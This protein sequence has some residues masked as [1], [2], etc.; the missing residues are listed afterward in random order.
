MKKV[1]KIFLLV[2]IFLLT[3]LFSF[4]CGEEGIKSIS[5]SLSNYQIVAGY[6][7]VKMTNNNINIDVKI[8]PNTIS[9]SDL[10][11][12]SSATDVVTVYNSTFKTRGTGTATITASYKNND[13]SV[14]K[15]YLRIK[16]VPASE[17]MSFSEDRYETNYTGQSL[18]S[19]YKVIQDNGTTQ[20]YT[21]SY[22]NADTRT[23]VDDI[24]DVGTYQITCTKTEGSNVQSCSTIL[25]V[26]KAV[27]NIVCNSYQIT[28]GDDFPT[29]LYSTSNI[30]EGILSND[31]IGS[32]LYGLG[33]DSSEKIGEYIQVTT[34]TKGANAKSYEINAYFEISD[35][36]QSNYEVSVANITK[37]S[38]TISPKD[39]V[40]SINNQ[41]ITY[42]SD[43]IGNNFSLYSYKEYTEAGNDISNL[44]PLDDT[45]TNYSTNIYLGSA[46]F[47]LDGVQATLN[48]VNCLNVLIN[49]EDNSYKS[50][51]LCYNSATTTSS[52]LYI[53]V[54][55]NG[56]LTVTPREVTVLPAEGQTKIFGDADP[57]SLAYT[58]VSG[59]FINRD[60]IPNFLQVNYKNEEVNLGEG[61]FLAGVNKY[62]YKV[63]NDINKN[64]KISL[65][66]LA[67]ED[68]SSPDANENKIRFEVIKSTIVIKL[69]NE[70]GN[71]STPTGIDA[72][73]E[74]IHSL[75]Y[76]NYLQDGTVPNY[77]AKPESIIINGEE[78]LNNERGDI[79]KN[80]LSESFEENG[81]ILLK[82]G[83]QLKFAIGLTQKAIPADGYFMSYEIKG[84]DEEGN[85]KYSLYFDGSANPDNFEVSIVSSTLNLR[86]LN[87]TII[88]N[89]TTS[90]VSKEYDAREGESSL[91]TGF[92]ADYRVT[93]DLD[94]KE[95][96]QILVNY[97]EVLSLLNENSQYTR[98]DEEGNENK[99]VS[100]IKDVGKYQIY[101]SK[102]LAYKTGME[103][104]DISL[105]VST[106]YYFTITKATALITPKLNEDG[107]N[108]NKV[109]GDA[110]P[111]EF[112]YDYLGVAESDIENFSG[113]LSRVKGENV[114]D[115]EI[116]LGDLTLGNNY[117]L[118]LSSTPIYF[119]ITKRE[120]K[121]EPISYETTYGD[122]YP[123]TIGY[124]TTIIGSYDESV[125]V[126]PTFTGV[127]EV[128]DATKI[129]GY[130][131]VCIDEGGN[132]SSYLIGR[133]TLACNDNY[134]MTFI[135][136]S[137]YKINKR[138]CVIDI[139]SQQI[140]NKDGLT[141]TGLV[142]SNAFYKPSNL[143]SG[144]T[145]VLTVNLN[146]TEDAYLDVK[147][148]DIKFEMGSGNDVTHCYAFSLGRKIVYY[149]D[150]KII[151]L[152]IVDAVGKSSSTVKVTYNGDYRENDFALI[153]QTEGFVVDE[154][155]SSYSFSY[156]IGNTSANPKDV[157]SYV[158]SVDLSGPNSK[159]VLKHSHTSTCPQD[160]NNAETIEFT[161]IDGSINKNC[162][163][164]ISNFGYLNIE[165][166]N[167]SYL[168]DKLSFMSPLTYGTN[169]ISNIKTTYTNDADSEVDIFY[170]V[171]TD[172]ISLLEVGGRNFYY[173]TSNYSLALLDANK[174]YPIE[175]TI[176]AEKNGTVDNNYNPLTI[177][178]P[179]QVIP[180]NLIIKGQQF[181]IGSGAD[182]QILPNSVLYDGLSRPV[183]ITLSI[184]NEVE[185]RYATTYNFVKLKSVYS[186]STKASFEYYD[187]KVDS[188]TGV[189][190]P[191]IVDGIKSQSFSGSG[192]SYIS[193]LIKLTYDGVDYLVIN[194]VYCALLEQDNVGTPLKAGVYVCIANCEAKTNY[195]FA[196]NEAQPV[197]IGTSATYVKMYEIEKSSDVSIDN[198][199]ESFYY[200]TQFDLANPETLPFE[201]EMSPNFK[202][203][204][205]YSMEE[206]VEWPS[207]NMLNV[208]NYSVTITVVND[209]Y[210]YS[211]AFTFEVTKLAAE[212]VF[213][214][215]KTYVY[216]GENISIVEFL[217]DIRILEK[218]KD[219]NTIN[220]FY[221]TYGDEN[222][223]ITLEFYEPF[224]ETALDYIPWDV[225]P[226]EDDFYTL[227]AKYGGDKSNYYGEGEFK[228][229]IIK[230]A[231]MGSVRF[232]N[233]TIIYNPSY[234]AEELYAL[235]YSNM[236]S[237][238]LQEG[239]EVSIFNENTTD[240]D[241]AQITPDSDGWILD[242]LEEGQKTLRLEVTFSDGITADYKAT[243][244]LTIEK[245]AVSQTEIVAPQSSTFTYT[246]YVVYNYLNFNTASL[247]PETLELNPSETL[248][249]QTDSDKKPYYL[250]YTS[251][252]YVY[253][254]FKT[255]EQ[256]NTVELKVKDNL[257]HVIFTVLYTYQYQDET[258][259][260]VEL[261]E[262]EGNPNAQN[263]T[264]VYH[265]PIDPKDTYYRVVY[266][267]TFGENYTGTAITLTY[268][269]FKINKIPTLYI[270]FNNNTDDSAIN[271]D[272]SNWDLQ[273]NN[274]KGLDD[275]FSQK[276]LVVKNQSGGGNVS[277]VKVNVQTNRTLGYTLQRR[278]G[279]HLFVYFTDYND[280]KITDSI[281]NANN[282]GENYNMYVTIMF[283]RYSNG[284]N[285][286]GS[287]NRPYYL[288][289]DYV[290]SVKFGSN[291]AVK[292]KYFT[293][294]R[295]FD[296]NNTELVDN[297][298]SINA[299]RSYLTSLS[300][301][302]VI[303]KYLYDINNWQEVFGS[304]NN[305]ATTST[306]NGGLMLKI[307][308]DSFVS[309]LSSNVNKITIVKNDGGENIPTGYEI[310]STGFS[311][312]DFV[313]QAEDYATTNRVYR[314][315]I[316]C[317][318][319]Y[320]SNAISF[321]VEKEIEQ[322][323]T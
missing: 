241:N 167:I 283:A 77:I 46:T 49:T 62:F 210:Y 142:L 223:L 276:L 38:L 178:I 69:K 35:N 117:T 118:I 300:Q 58:V 319:N 133:G 101:L 207:N 240:T 9:V 96:E 1:L 32:S 238:G 64:Y 127:L 318:T 63:N 76:Y 314:F 220:S 280:N 20:D 245:M 158:A 261:K 273:Y 301:Q 78:I 138:I 271:S 190:Y 100:V 222:P 204:V 239:Y 80:T 163:L 274:I 214:T 53:A 57:A 87:I 84:T 322:P 229:K 15:G 51:D 293:P 106:I 282:D 315:I 156:V 296:D 7:N 152:A 5:L 134:F 287:N 193:S 109:Y 12:E 92:M 122:D 88:P 141:T 183:T 299:E 292:A 212:F 19:N 230:K 37:G 203:Q 228:Y 189:G 66:E 177:S 179:L 29:E 172:S 145:T 26:N 209:N 129:N 8:E 42:G 251:G 89:M 194:D 85:P 33:K 313:A 206:P 6:Y 16:V 41:T 236:F 317:K 55:L 257:G 111:E 255:K 123:T 173:S 116:T 45:T 259:A 28:Y 24:V 74:P 294:G 219:G 140:E 323:T 170:G 175:V 181:N 288:I 44:T 272:W 154:D 295:V 227:K 263:P 120:V 321:I 226:D 217:N 264:Y 23:T 267:Y 309:N 258:G 10:T 157:G 289:S 82:T 30:P 60:N 79:T 305:I 98:V 316:D 94:G 93:G 254:V 121:V 125:L 275:R 202:D 262:V 160:C 213:P 249:E 247:N 75:S 11:W 198:W 59:T 72:S 278:S 18:A 306:T 39:V 56:K 99:K 102:R 144:T 137:T 187:Y 162:V 298:A 186:D 279:I 73:G 265:L 191:S 164:N 14:V 266:S 225:L 269:N 27:I 112:T 304:N 166:A 40:L 90:L 174:S 17:S 200:T 244:I 232:Q 3:V 243:A 52:N 253:T 91:P 184:A 320:T 151:D 135:E 221:Y 234:T 199:K 148:Y 182:M 50:Y 67:K 215:T 224:N 161:A 47:M 22:F 285:E 197:V 155:A 147:E 4:A 176:Q 250:Q 260:F 185:K 136:T 195:I 252:R 114:G 242:L 165:R 159:I 218:D 169:T 248:T 308:E 208:G 290:E 235:I 171:G 268:K 104:Y 103:Y 188:Q 291:T 205:E 286:E 131:P 270:S 237:I 132:V 297:T 139:I 119:S 256:G 108:Q 128:K 284:P 302:V 61:N 211:N 233:T 68:N 216:K 13:G 126:A 231:Y 71:Y 311:F 124:Y 97:T 83:G 310:T 81:F 115:Y 168:S 196:E 150:V 86:K 70:K 146:T 36:Y 65:G 48:D 43:I 107:S 180:Q 21:Y 149:I 143:L 192:L 110:D 105:D 95:I 246:G 25:V 153:C 130:Y 277:N 31:Q 54:K 307:T 2:P 312:A 113:N 281:K 34:A 303:S 201:Y